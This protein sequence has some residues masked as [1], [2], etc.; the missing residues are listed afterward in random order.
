MRIQR[1][2]TGPAAQVPGPCPNLS[3]MQKMYHISCKTTRDMIHFIFFSYIRPYTGYFF[4]PKVI[5]LK[6]SRMQFRIN[7]RAADTVASRIVCRFP[8]K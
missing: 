2:Q 7:V 3:R 5:L 4:L 6:Y 8:E 1:R